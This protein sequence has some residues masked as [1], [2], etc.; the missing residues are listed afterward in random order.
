MDSHGFAFRLLP[1]A[2]FEP[3]LVRNRPPLLGVWGCRACGALAQG[4][5]SRNNLLRW[6]N[7]AF[8]DYKQWAWLGNWTGLKRYPAVL[9]GFRCCCVSM[10][11]TLSCCV[12]QSLH[13][14]CQH[15][16]EP[17]LA[18]R[19]VQSSATVGSLDIIEPTAIQYCIPESKCNCCENSIAK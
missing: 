7:F 8:W 12:A 17:T 3:C 9:V 19:T 14:G 2:P 11:W 10:M 4:T 6:S 13:Q 15:P 1:W 5:P 16:F 18:M